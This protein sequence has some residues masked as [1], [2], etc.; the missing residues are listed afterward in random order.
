MPKGEKLKAKATVST[1][2]CEFQK[3]LCL[4]LVF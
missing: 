1:I 2:I 4:V 3:S